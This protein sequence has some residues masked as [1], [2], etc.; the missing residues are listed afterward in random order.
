MSCLRA[1][2]DAA[3]FNNWASLLHPVVNYEQ[4]LSFSL[5]HACRAQDAGFYR[6]QS[7]TSPTLACRCFYKFRVLCLFFVSAV[8]FCL[9]VFFNRA[10]QRVW[11]PNAEIQW[12]DLDV[13]KHR[14]QSAHTPGGLGGRA[15][16]HW[17]VSNIITEQVLL[18]I[19]KSKGI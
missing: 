5:T 15:G 9:F 16:G 19:C 11:G 17:A 6:E 1:E 8:L 2:P 4:G 14:Q 12:T 13:Q 18:F 3:P 10:V 7:I